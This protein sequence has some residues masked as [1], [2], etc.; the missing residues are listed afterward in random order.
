M[1]SVRMIAS[2]AL[3][4]ALA[5]ACPR[6]SEE[7]RIADFVK[8][9]VGLAEKR[10]VAG[11]MGRLA[12]DYADF[13]GRGKSA[14]ESLVRDYFRRTGIVIHLLNVKVDSI[15]PDGRA[16][17]RLEVMLS[18]GAA[19]VFRKLIRYAGDYYRFSLR[20]KKSPDVT[21][22][23]E[24]AAWESVGLDQLL[25]ESLNVLKKLFPDI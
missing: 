23:V 5:C 18:S 20:L 17:V 19:E 22:Q 24:F 3:I 16:S 14:T 9:T 15:E 6:P 12:E 1:R 7:S 11:V 21:F 4:T 13:E 25:P 10:D 2:V 8:E